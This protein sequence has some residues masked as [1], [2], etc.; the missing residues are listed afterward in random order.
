ML[1]N[2]K[3]IDKLL[4]RADELIGAAE[5]KE[6]L[7]ELGGIYER[8]HKRCA[9]A[10]YERA[11]LLSVGEG[12][13]LLTWLTFLAEYWRLL[14]DRPDM[15]EVEY[16]W[17]KLPDLMDAK[18]LQK[19]SKR[20]IVLQTLEE[21]KVLSCYV[22]RFIC[23]DITAWVDI[24]EGEEFRA[25]L[26]R[27][28]GSMMDQFVIFRIPAVDEVTLRR[29]REAISWFMNVEVLY[30]PPYSI[31]D[32]VTYAKRRF[33]A[34]DVR[35]EKEAEKAFFDI[36]MNER[37][38]RAF[39]GFKTVRTIVDDLIYRKLCSEYGDTGSDE[40]EADA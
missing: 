30:Q 32:Y 40:Q 14:L 6:Y 16:Y 29:V 11:I 35:L 38:S 18:D 2:Q 24:I 17:L 4:Q 26:S 20:D 31:E 22:R 9:P 7:H 19:T 21:D 37:R 33:K 36:I 23:V 3:E 28:K 10:L 5:L 13:G 8:L 39:C 27:F 15:P 12:D 25:V 34:K 1:K